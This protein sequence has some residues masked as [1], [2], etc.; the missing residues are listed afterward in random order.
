MKLISLN[1]WG[2]KIFEPLIEFIKNSA[3]ST[4]IFCFQE[5]FFGTEPKNDVGGARANLAQELSILLPKFS[6]Y[7]RFAPEGSY[8]IKQLAASRLGQAIFI[9]K[10][11]SIIDK[12]G[13]YTYSPNNPIAPVLNHSGI[14][15]YLKIKTNGEEFIVGN[16]HGLWQSGGKKDT[17]ERFEQSKILKNFYNSQSGKKIL[18]GDFNLRP[19]TQSIAMLEEDFKN[20]IKEYNTPTTRTYFYKDAKKYND[21]IADYILV[22]PDIKI[23]SF[24][25]LVGKAVSDHLAVAVELF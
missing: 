23:K 9:R 24:A 14:F 17:L 7:P 1:A 3:D 12:S 25:V 19:E 11:I 2:G 13:F 6:M 4:D 22:S 10:N 15:Q 8:F 20:L 5:L 21:Y 16:I 18:C